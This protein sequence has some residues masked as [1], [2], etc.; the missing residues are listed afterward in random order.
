MAE[1][2]PQQRVTRIGQLEAQIHPLNSRR[3][4]LGARLS[5]AKENLYK[6]Y[7]EAKSKEIADL[8]AEIAALNRQL[9][10]LFRELQ[11]LRAFYQ[12]QYEGEITRSNRTTYMETKVEY[13]YLVTDFEI[14]TYTNGWDIYFGVP[15][16]DELINEIMTFLYNHRFSNFNIL[17]I[18]RVR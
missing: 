3:I 15:G 5:A 8:H 12:V 1:L 7:S 2:T 9:E 6:D 18:K 11:I 14:D 16:C 17:N 10:P 13:L 4:F